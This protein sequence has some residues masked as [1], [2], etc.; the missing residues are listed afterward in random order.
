MSDVI[1][2]LVREPHP[3]LLILQAFLSF[4]VATSLGI[5]AMTVAECDSDVLASVSLCACSVVFF[6]YGLSSLSRTKHV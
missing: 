1:R 5:S 3:V 6:I 2:Y 4:G